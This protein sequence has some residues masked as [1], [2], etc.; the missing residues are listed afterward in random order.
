MAGELILFEHHFGGFDDDLDLVAFF[1]P[2]LFG[3]A[4]GDHAFDLIF[5]DPDDDVGHDVAEGDFDHFTFEL[6][7][8]GEWHATSLVQARDPDLNELDAFIFTS[9]RQELYFGRNG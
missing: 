9:V 2:E 1:Q 7:A 4:A 6:I 3:A 5:P 8:R